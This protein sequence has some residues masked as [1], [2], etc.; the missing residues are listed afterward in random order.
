[1]TAHST[2]PKAPIG[3]HAIVQGASMAGLLAARVLA[4]F[5]TTVTLVE[6][7]TLGDTAAVRKGVPQGRHAH[8]LLKRGAQ[9]LEELFPGFLDQLVDDG[10]AVFDGTDLSKMYFCMNGHLAVRSGAALGLRTYNTTRPFLEWQV[11]RRVRALPNVVILDGHD[12][13]DV[14][15]RADG[16]TG[17]RVASRHSSVASEL[18]ADLV[19]D[20]TG[21]GA[22]TPALLKRLGYEPPAEDEVVVDL[23]YASQLLR[24]PGEVLH[25]SG[26]IVSPV[27]G[28]PTGTA[29][30]KCENDTLFFTVF[31]SRLA[32]TT[33]TFAQ[34]PRSVLTSDAIASSRC[35]Q[36]S[37]SRS[38]RRSPTK[39][40][41]VSTAE[42]P[43]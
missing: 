8:G 37:S 40:S 34:A 7:D 21:R 15:V 35:S 1:M 2:I 20:A 12:V 11:R 32:A 38:T 29:I 41:R 25:E 28:R 26:L 13:A 22:R 6:R 23:M 42:R 10:A 18:T 3:K 39:V 19:V 24:L 31:G 17:A 43:G 4:D 9:A 33:F 36:L 16:V 14:R 5:Y 30:I 27:A